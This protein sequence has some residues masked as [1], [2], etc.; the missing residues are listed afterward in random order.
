MS[1]TDSAA[2][3]LCWRKARASANDGACVEV[4]SASGLVAVRDS[5]NPGGSRLYYSARSWCEFTARIRQ[6]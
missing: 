4:A 1:P 6:R 5:K 3:V 2:R